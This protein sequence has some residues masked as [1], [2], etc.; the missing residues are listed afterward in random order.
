MVEHVNVEPALGADQRSQ[1]PNWPRAGDQQRFRLPCARAPPNALGMRPGL[2]DDTGR[3]DQNTG[4]A[5]NW[6]DLDQKLRLDAEKIRTVAVAFL[7]AAFGVTAVAA[8]IPFADRAGRTR[9]RI[10]PP[11]N[12]DDK[13][14]GLESG[15]GRSLL[16]L[17]ERFVAD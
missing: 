14:A 6:I 3:L 7:D 12:P 8:H 13:I 10:G 15:I 17:A 9:H 4:I 2:G 11:H 16:N 5:E 1:Q